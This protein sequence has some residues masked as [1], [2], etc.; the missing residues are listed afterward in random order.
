MFI[1]PLIFPRFYRTIEI[2]R[3]RYRAL[4]NRRLTSLDHS[5]QFFIIIFYNGDQRYHSSGEIVGKLHD[6]CILHT[7]FIALG[8]ILDIQDQFHEN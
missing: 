1:I 8:F 4:L 6:I 7:S 5:V 2:A 3:L